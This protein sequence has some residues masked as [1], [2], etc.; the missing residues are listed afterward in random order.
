MTPA[1]VG[2]LAAR[3]HAIGNHT[4]THKRLVGLSPENLEREIG[5]SSRKLSAWTKKPVDAF[6]WTFGWHEIDANAWQAIRRYHR[7]CFS[8]CVGA[9]DTRCDRPPLLWRREIEVRYSA[10]EFRFA[11]SGLVDFWWRTRRRYLRNLLRVS[12]E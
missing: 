9:I 5:D 4:L 8:P 2:D 12:P 11:Y 3:G 10:P 1:Q 7:F 6:A